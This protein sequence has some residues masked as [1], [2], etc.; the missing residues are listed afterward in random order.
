MRTHIETDMRGYLA[1]AVLE[2]L[3]MFPFA[4][5]NVI[6]SRGKVTD[7]ILGHCPHSRALIYTMSSFEGF[8]RSTRELADREAQS[9]TYVL[10]DDDQLPIGHDWL[11]A[12]ADA[13]EARP[14]FA[15]VSSWSVNGEVPA[16]LAGDTRD[17]SYVFGADSCG[18]P[19]FVRKGTFVNLPDAPAPEYDLV[20]SEHLRKT[21]GR[22]GFLTTVRHNHL[23][24][25]YS[26]VIRGHWSA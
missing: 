20:L 3:S 22:I 6:S 24:Y 12:G 2:R 9:S 23:G 19:C 1:L 13:L 14:D 26:Q 16:P 5:V 11:S 25:E 7:W 18:T 8:A 4:R 15:M 10:I 21:V 17:A